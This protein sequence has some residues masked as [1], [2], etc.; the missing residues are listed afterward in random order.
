MRNKDK[1]GGGPRQ[2]QPKSSQNTRNNRPEK[3][4]LTIERLS[5]DGRG[6]AFNKKRAIFIENALAGET[7]SATFS[8]QG[9]I[10]AGETIAVEKASDDRVDPSCELFGQ[11][12]GCQLQ[13]ASYE[14]QLNAKQQNFVFKMGRA[15]PTAELLPPLS[16]KPYQYRSRARFAFV[17]SLIGFR[18]RRSTKIIGLETCPLLETELN[19]ALPALFEQLKPALKKIGKG[20]FDVVVDKKGTIG[21]SLSQIDDQ[22]FDAQRQLFNEALGEQA[23]LSFKAANTDITFKAGDFTQVNTDINQQITERVVDWLAPN[24]QD[25][26]ADYFCGLGNF[27]FPLAQS[28]VQVIGF[29]ADDAMVSRANES[30]K[31]NNPSNC[32]FKRM[33]LFEPIAAVNF[34]S[35]NKAVLDPPRAGARKLC[36]SLLGSAV[37]RI[38]YVSCNPETLLRDLDILSGQYDV[39]KLAMADMFPQTQHVEAMALLQRK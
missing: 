19:D 9:K 35:L 11:C 5:D 23:E 25:R 3:A 24:K 17:G 37:E 7:V 21:A 36:E 33:D 2:F 18:A 14:H 22:Q 29:E 13:H 1:R 15:F 34:Q 32:A 6:L 20:E 26:I 4:S 39:Q 38:V 31:A 30:G 27:S 12:G 8:K 16:S 10:W 28:A